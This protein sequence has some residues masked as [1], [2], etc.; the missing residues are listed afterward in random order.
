M[1]SKIQWVKI[2]DFIDEISFGANNIAEVSADD[3]KI[4]I[5]KFQ[6]E[7]FA[8]ANKCPHASG[9]LSGGFIDA[10]GNVVC[11]LHQYRFSMRNGRNASGEGYYLKHWPVEK[12]E[13]G[14]FVGFK[15]NPL[16]SLL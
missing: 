12:R 13:D 1:P 2:A 6:N 7:L 4:C 3:K 5:G 11:P 10:L 16:S 14:I 15:I 8:F 9:P